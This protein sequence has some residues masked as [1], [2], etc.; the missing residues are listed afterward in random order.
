MTLLKANL[1]NLANR[2]REKSSQQIN[3]W[4]SAQ[5]WELGNSIQYMNQ[6][7]FADALEHVNNPKFQASTG[8][9]DDAD[10]NEFF[11]GSREIWIQFMQ[12]ITGKRVMEIGPCLLAKIAY[13]D[14]AS[15]RIAIEPLFDEIS[16]YQNEVYGK[17]WLSWS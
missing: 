5:L 7:S 3:P 2:L 16:K 12:Q 14:V 17:K 1:R 10:L 4:E 9:I 13:W 8:F 15:E 11:S 6:H